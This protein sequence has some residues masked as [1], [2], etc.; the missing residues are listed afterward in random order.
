MAQ[1]EE[2]KFRKLR[3]FNGFMGVLHLIQGSLMLIL[4]QDFSKNVFPIIGRYLS[5]NE[6]TESL[7]MIQETL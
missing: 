1:D 5:Y 6:A 2:T 3:R 4:S 7:E